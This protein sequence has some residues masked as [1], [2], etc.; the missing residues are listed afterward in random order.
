MSELN[1]PFTVPVLLAGAQ[2]VLDVILILI[3]LFLLK[4]ISAFD[5][6]KFSQLID[7]LRESEELCRKLGR[8]VASNAEIACNLENLINSA[9]G[10]QRGTGNRKPGSQDEVLALWQ[11]G[12]TIGEIAEATGLGRGEVEVI[13]ALSAESAHKKQ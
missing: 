2:I 1:I 7:T 8:T 11:K 12:R 3:V 5:P 6:A 9:G 13:T 4:R 10:R